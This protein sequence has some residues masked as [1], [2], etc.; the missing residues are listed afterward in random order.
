MPGATGAIF[1]IFICWKD[2]LQ[3]F[4]DNIRKLIQTYNTTNLISLKE[5]VVCHFLYWIQY[6]NKK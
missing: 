6:Y 1:R 2:I 4:W 3:K 5:L